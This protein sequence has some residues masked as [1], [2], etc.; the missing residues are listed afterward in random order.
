M[1]IGVHEHCGHRGTFGDFVYEDQ[2][3]SENWIDTAQNFGGFRPFLIDRFPTE[4]SQ[5]DIGA[6]TRFL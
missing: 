4:K 2:V 5:I 3:I 1:P 6:E